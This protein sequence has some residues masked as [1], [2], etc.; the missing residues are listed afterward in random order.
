MIA[1]KEVAWFFVVG[2]QL[3]EPISS[4]AGEWSGNMSVEV[5]SFPVEPLVADQAHGNIS[6]AFQPEYFHEWAEGDQR[7][8][9]SGFLRLDR[10]D[11]R[12][13][14][15]DIRELFWE[16]TADNWALVIGI[17]K[18]FWG[19]AES[20]H[21]SDII[22]QTDLVEHPDGEEKLGQPM[23]N[24]ALIRTWGTLEC[25]LLPGFRERT[26]PGFD[27]RLR[28]HPYV[29][30]DQT[31][32]D[33]EAQNRHVNWAM[34]W[35]HTFG[36]FDIGIAHFAGTGREPRMV[37]GTD[38]TG[39]AVLKPCYYLVKHT[40]LDFQA[41]REGWLWKLEASV[42][43][44]QNDSFWAWTTGLEYFLETWVPPGK[45]MRLIVEYSFDSRGEG[46]STPFD[47]DAFCGIHLSL[48]DAQ[49][50][51]FQVDTMV[52][53]KTGALV[54]RGR[55]NRRLRSNWKVEVEVRSYMGASPVD[56]LF[57]LQRDDYLQM[58]LARYF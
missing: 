37:P 39:S 54:A 33:P 36:D 13:T 28:S 55:C 16:K 48:N 41:T 9:F 47:N 23:V 49:S 27:G 20:R 52:D 7:L 35:S 17:G 8:I 21:L 31:F 34:R 24:M 38:E 5:R 40:S 43:D 14:H 45:D 42:Q 6:L 44:R 58:E 2:L 32:F 10:Q 51:N 57:G 30:T 22:N 50:T 46:A 56:P 18:I 11:E 4:L 19:V 12:R 53:S 29:D 3:L 25:F 15:W 26:W 1:P